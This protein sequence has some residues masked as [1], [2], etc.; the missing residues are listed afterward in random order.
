MDEMEKT[1][2]QNNIK[3]L[4]SIRILVFDLVGKFAHFGNLNI[5][6]I[7]TSYPFPPRTAIAGLL[8]S[9]MELESNEYHS[10]F[11]PENVR[12]ASRIVSPYRTEIF[13]INYINT[14]T[15]SFDINKKEFMRG[16][17][18]ISHEIIFPKDMDD[19]LR[20]RIYV[21]LR[22]GYNFET[23]YGK[24]ELDELYKKIKNREWGYG[25]YLG[26]AT[27]IGYIENPAIYETNEYKI[28][29]EV[30]SIATVV[31]LKSVKAFV[32]GVKEV[33]VSF[34]TITIAFDNNRTPL[35][36]L[37]VTWCVD[38]KPFKAKVNGR[39]FKTEDGYYGS[40]LE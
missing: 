30:I 3:V 24:M 21:S 29:E 26:M 28:D 10:Q 15:E 32:G 5:K 27:C 1:G 8:A 37:E 9:I 23:K 36:S 20:Y 25:V 34:D 38:A 11:S 35:G 33:R 18:Q 19:R 39:F 6:S 13:A 17:T 4:G 14:K 16:R 7:R 31:P 2:E 12:I 22:E 40:F